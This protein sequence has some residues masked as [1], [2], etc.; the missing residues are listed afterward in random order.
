MNLDKVMHLIDWR[1]RQ[2]L[3]MLTGQGIQRKTYCGKQVMDFQEANRIIG[4]AIMAGDPFMVGRFGS[5]ELEAMQTV[6]DTNDGFDYS[7]E[8][9]LHQLC[10]YSGFFPEDKELLK[11]FAKMMR[12]STYQAD[13]IGVWNLKFE[14][15]E[16]KKNGNNPMICKLEAIEP[17]FSENPWTKNLEGKRVLVIHPFSETIKRQYSKRELLFN[18]KDVLPEFE[19]IVQTAVQTIADNR[20][21]RFTDWFEALDYMYDRAMSVDFDVAI[22][23]CGAYGFPLAAKIK[24][25]GKI[26][27]HMGGA[28]Q[29]LFGIKGKRWENNKLYMDNGLINSYWIRPIEQPLN[30]NKIENGC[31][32]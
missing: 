22:I 1:R 28:T 8:K 20:D 6:N 30:Y 11:K 29:C 4:N 18:N 17:F 26:A 2:I 27:I 7:P 23:G 12:D 21:G 31:Y 24:K 10:Y 19:L 14:D 5:S 15:Y 16:I 13:M 32:W 3:G 25:A 9:A